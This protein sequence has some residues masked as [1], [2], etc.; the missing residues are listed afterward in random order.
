MSWAGNE[1]IVW[2]CLRLYPGQE[3]SALLDHTC[4][5][6]S[7]GNKVIAWSCI[8][9]CP[10]QEINVSFHHVCV[11]APARK[12]MHRLIMHVLYPSGNKSIACSCMHSCPG[13]EWMYHLIMQRVYVLDRKWMFRLIMHILCPHQEINH[14]C[15]IS[16]PGNECIAWS[17]MRLCPDQ[18]MNVLLYHTCVYV[19]AR[20]WMQH[21][22]M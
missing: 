14:A 1:R 9:L 5:I 4:F 17:C 16:W 8:R 3:K 21:L 20:K 12:R 7:P 13:Q 15:D 11:F 22:I 6:S 19:L 18:K 2:S 10:S